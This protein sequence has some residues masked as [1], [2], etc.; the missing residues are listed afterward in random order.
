MTF[1]H[2]RVIHKKINYLNKKMHKKLKLTI[3]V[4]IDVPHFIDFRD[5]HE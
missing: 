2:T 3:T 1:T 4:E 5:G